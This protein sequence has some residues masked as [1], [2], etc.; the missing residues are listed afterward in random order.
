MRL[1]VKNYREIMNGN[2]GGTTGPKR[3]VVV[4]P[5]KKIDRSALEIER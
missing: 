2:D 4:G 3:H 1:R 5:M